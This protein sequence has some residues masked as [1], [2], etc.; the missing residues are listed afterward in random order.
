MLKA[1]SHCIEYAKS[2]WP[3]ADED[4]I[5]ILITMSFGECD[6]SCEIA[7]SI[8]NAAKSMQNSFEIDRIL[9]YSINECDRILKLLNDHPDSEYEIEEIILDGE[10]NSDLSHIKRVAVRLM[11]CG[12]CGFGVEEIFTK[13]SHRDKINH[14]VVVP[15]LKCGSVHKFWIN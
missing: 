7:E 4:D 15:C 9:Q 5:V 13:G 12:A 6:V 11:V 3:D 1:C 8:L 14:P 2:L 10:Y